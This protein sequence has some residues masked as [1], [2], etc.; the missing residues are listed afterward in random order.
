MT[1]EKNIYKEFLLKVKND[2]NIFIYNDYIKKQKPLKYLSVDL[3]YD[4]KGKIFLDLEKN[5]YF[6]NNIKHKLQLL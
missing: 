5:I 4:A 6:F 3:E 2:G 1:L